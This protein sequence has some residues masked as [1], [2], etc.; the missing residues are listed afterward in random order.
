MVE[1]A[2]R[3]GPKVA[4]EA[5]R[6]DVGDAL[7]AYL[8]TTLGDPALAYASPPS[9]ITGGFDTAIYAFALGGADGEMAGPLILRVFR[10]GRAEQAR[11]ESVAQ[12]AVA[13][14]GYPAPRVLL[15]CE[16]STVLGG[17][18]TIMPR[19]PGT[20]MLSRIFGPAMTRMPVVLAQ[21]QAR[22][23]ALDPEPVRRALAA[24]GFGDERESAYGD[25]AWAKVIEAM[26][27]DGL[28]DACAWVEAGR[29]PSKRAAVLCHGD[30]HPLN[31]MMVGNTVAGVLDWANM[32]IADPAWD[33]GAAI[34]LF[35]HGPVDLPRPVVPIV[36]L[37]RRWLLRRYVNAYLAQ[38]PLE[39]ASVRY[40]EAVR[41][42]EFMM[43]TEVY[44]RAKAGAIAPTTKAAPFNDP[45]VLRGIAK[46]FTAITGVPVSLP[47]DRG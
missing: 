47:E 43:E 18:F 35:G 14:Q 2:S 22:L 5:P 7:I 8:R 21:A 20:V 15:S 39:V 13:A 17:A 42:L 9:P 46:R 1:Q 32:R 28:R 41:L 10:D 19:V 37:V 26:K 25:A 24:G 11:F 12:N 23:H 31:V 40:Y 27:L 34:A 16:D 38:R 6:A 36:N 29:P 30:F 33:V 45:R 44:R 4:D 3:I